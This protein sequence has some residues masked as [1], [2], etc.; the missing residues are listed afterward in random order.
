MR[1]QRVSIGIIVFVSML[2]IWQTKFCIFG[3]LPACQFV[4]GLT[5]VLVY[6]SLAGYTG[7]TTDW[8][9]PDTGYVR[10]RFPRRVS[11]VL[12]NPVRSV[13]SRKS[14]TPY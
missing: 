1:L 6:L 11:T 4:P 9:R 5:K 2:N 7:V 13:I 8:V 12:G 14:G 10:T 3:H